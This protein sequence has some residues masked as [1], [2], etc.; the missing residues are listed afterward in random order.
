MIINFRIHR[1]SRDAH[2]LTRKPTIIKY[3]YTHTEDLSG[4][5]FI[6]FKK[7]LCPQPPHR[8]HSWLALYFNGQF[9]FQ[10][11]CE[12]CFLRYYSKFYI[13]IE[14]DWLFRCL[15]GIV[16]IDP[17][18]IRKHDPFQERNEKVGSWTPGIG[19]KNQWKDSY[20]DLSFFFPFD[21]C[22]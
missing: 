22:G 5:Y 15:V 13:H 19:K 16:N 1:I 2:K 18:F 7:K 11:V 6:F 14:A 9:P 12:S 17:Y 20:I 8:L 4:F 10:P 3:I 21:V